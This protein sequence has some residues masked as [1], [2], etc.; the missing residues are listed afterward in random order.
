MSG[1][2]KPIKYESVMKQ[3]TR[4]VIV[5]FLPLCITVFACS[6]NPVGPADNQDSEQ[7]VAQQIEMSGLVKTP[8]YATSPLLITFEKSLSSVGIWKGTV[9]GDVAGGLTTEL[10]DLKE[11]GPIWHVVFDWIIGA[12]DQSFTARLNGTLNNN[13]GKVVMNGTITEGWLKGA[14]VHE[15]GQ[16]ID[17]DTMGFEGTIQIN[18][19]TTIT[20]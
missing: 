16:L 18:P 12:G 13:T 15:E 9:D 2:I 5:S 14:R 1:F 20:E 4:C 19:R 3:L 11:T 6:K 8:D 10:I 7:Y 17:P